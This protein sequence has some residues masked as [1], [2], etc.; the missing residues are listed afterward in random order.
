V[1]TYGGGLIA[2]RGV[3][4]AHA[5]NAPILAPDQGVAHDHLSPG[6][7]GSQAL[8]IISRE[9]G[10]PQSSTDFLKRKQ[11]STLKQRGK[12]VEAG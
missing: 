11:V 10:Y 2:R 6:V 9:I 3:K 12:R 1:V 8:S 5:V 4:R 7:S